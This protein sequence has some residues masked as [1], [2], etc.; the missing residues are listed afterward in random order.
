MQFYRY[1]RLSLRL[2][3]FLRREKDRHLSRHFSHAFSHC[4]TRHLPVCSGK[5]SLWGTSDAT[6]AKVIQNVFNKH[7]NSQTNIENQ[8]LGKRRVRYFGLGISELLPNYWASS[9]MGRMRTLSTGW[10]QLVDCQGYYHFVH[11]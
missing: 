7:L 3:L 8:H 10:I 9:P 6:Y 5:F 11:P 2:K 1:T 4:C